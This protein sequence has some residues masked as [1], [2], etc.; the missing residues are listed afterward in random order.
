[1]TRYLPVCLTLTN[2]MQDTRPLGV[3]NFP[4]GMFW[5]RMTLNP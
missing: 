1:M 2:S 4:L 3:R 5:P